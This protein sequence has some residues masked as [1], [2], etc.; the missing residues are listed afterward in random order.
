MRITCGSR[1]YRQVI[2]CWPF[3]KKIR[4][5]RLK[6]ELNSD[7]PETVFG[8]CTL[9]PEPAT[10]IL[11]FRS[12]RNDGNCFSIWWIFQFLV[13][14]QP[15]TITRN[16]IVNDK[17]HLVQLFDDSGKTDHYNYSAV[18]LT[19]SFWQM[20]S[21]HRVSKRF[22]FKMVSAHT[23]AFTNSSGKKSVFGKLRFRDGLVWMV[24]LTVEIKLRFQISPA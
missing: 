10:A 5:F 8:K 4:K 12:K 15:K 22:R 14:H 7:F 17:R 2:G 16:R 9:P 11:L 18:I 20:V 19:G 23:P 21:T 13:S 24:G 1:D 3:S 6:V